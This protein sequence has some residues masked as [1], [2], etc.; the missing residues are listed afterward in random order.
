[1]TLTELIDRLHEL[2]AEHGGE[3]PVSRWEI[4]E[5]VLASE[6]NVDLGLVLD[7]VL[8]TRRTIH[9]VKID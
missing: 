9:T 8:G 5:W 2:R 6:V 3:V 7:P 4:D 1:M